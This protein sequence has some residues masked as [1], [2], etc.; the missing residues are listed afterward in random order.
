MTAVLP[1]SVASTFMDVS[2]RDK[3]PISRMQVDMWSLRANMFR[4]ADTRRSVGPA[5]CDDTTRYVIN[6]KDAHD[7]TISLLRRQCLPTSGYLN[8][9]KGRQYDTCMTLQG[10]FGLFSRRHKDNMIRIHIYRLSG[11]LLLVVSVR[12]IN[13]QGV[14]QVDKLSCLAGILAFNLNC[15]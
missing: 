10:N 15:E 6:T 13:L 11:R 14:V 12:T 5:A 3:I 9:S 7:K 1:L 2:M 4:K 8:W